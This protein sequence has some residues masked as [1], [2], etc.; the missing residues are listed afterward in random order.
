MSCT[1]IEDLDPGKFPPGTHNDLSH[2]GITPGTTHTG[3]PH[4]SVRHAGAH[5]GGYASAVCAEGAAVAA[6]CTCTAHGAR[7]CERV[8]EPGGECRP[9]KCWCPHPAGM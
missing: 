2:A 9:C 3:K 4:W 1:T 8:P 5:P 6:Y 7:C